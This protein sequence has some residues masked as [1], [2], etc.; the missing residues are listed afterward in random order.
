[1]FHRV[2]RFIAIVESFVRFEVALYR[3][4]GVSRNPVFSIRFWTPAFAGV[5]DREKVIIS[6]NCYRDQQ[7]I[8]K[9][10]A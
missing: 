3:H 9:E 5:T 2:F 10:E 1:M 4:S 7:K 6:G 8:M